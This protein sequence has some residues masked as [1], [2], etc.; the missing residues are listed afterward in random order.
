MFS[1]GSTSR[2]TDLHVRRREETS[3]AGVIGSPWVRCTTK[4]RLQKVCGQ[5]CLGSLFSG[6]WWQTIAGRRSSAAKLNNQHWNT[7]GECIHTSHLLEPYLWH[8]GVHLSSRFLWPANP[9]NYFWQVFPYFLS[10]YGKRLCKISVNGRSPFC[11]QKSKL[12]LQTW[13]YQLKDQ[14]DIQLITNTSHP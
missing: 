4:R 1:W 3:A 12:F 13:L 7:T 10:A 6:A 2:G 8:A 5:H 11:S 14:L 9:S